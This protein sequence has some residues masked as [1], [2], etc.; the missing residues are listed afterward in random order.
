MPSIE[1]L[2]PALRDDP[3]FVFAG[4]LLPD[5]ALSTAGCFVD[6]NA[7]SSF[8]VRNNSCGIALLTLGT[9]QKPGRLITQIIHHLLSIGLA[10][11]TTVPVSE[12]P[13]SFLSRLHY[14]KWVP[15]HKACAASAFMIHHCGSATY[16][17]AILHERPSICLGSGFHDRD[18]VA[19]QLEDLGVA[20]YLP[21]TL[22]PDGIFARFQS[23]LPDLVDSSSPW[24][25][26]AQSSLG[27]LA[28]EYRST[29][30][31]FDFAALLES[32]VRDYKVEM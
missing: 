10:V 8:L 5:D 16:Q 9:T 25:A 28:N 32:V 7:L 24:R 26:S 27:A 29:S 14:S 21:P 4:S 12:I 6:M 18:D 1:L 11:V 31:S 15:M 23:T 2:P 3:Q 20:K 22:G 13:S 17:Y 30:A 19:T